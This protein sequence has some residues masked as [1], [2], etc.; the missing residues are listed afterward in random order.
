MNHLLSCLMCTLITVGC[1]K[2]QPKPTPEPSQQSKQPTNDGMQIP[3]FSGAR[4]FALLVKQT[5]FGP[6]NPGSSGHA[7]CQEFLTSEM[8]KYAD[9]VRLQEFSHTGY[10][11]EHFQL[12]NIL[13]SFNAQSKG[14]ILLCAHW[15]TRP[16]GEND[17]NRS[18]RSEP[19]V[20]ANDGASGV[21][22]LL[23]IAS[24]FKK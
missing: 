7:V 24:L 5:N 17:E 15:D 12:T 8:R 3:T 20:G 13:A 23:E 18:R 6:R 4:S 19:I 10:K 11:G 16:R 22:V 2:E 9:E 14:R 21:A 1:V